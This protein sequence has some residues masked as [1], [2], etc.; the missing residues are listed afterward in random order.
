MPLFSTFYPELMT[1]LPRQRNSF[2]KGKFFIHFN[3]EPENI[4]SGISK[5][6]QT[7][8]EAFSRY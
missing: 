3:V 1:M 6:E 8:R 4:D 5:I 7:I 2:V